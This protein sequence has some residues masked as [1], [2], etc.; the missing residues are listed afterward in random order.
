MFRN[1]RIK[2]TA[3]Y[4]LI[5]MCISIAFS[6]VIYRVLS[7]EVERFAT[8]QRVRIERRIQDRILLPNIP[9]PDLHGQINLMD[10]DLVGETQHRLILMLLF[11]NS[12][13]LLIAGALGYVLAGK[14][15]KPIASMV[16]EQHRFI[17]DASHELRTPITALKTS[18]EVGLRDKQ[19]TITD[20]KKLLSENIEEINSLQVLSEK[21]LQ[22]S[23]YES[24]HTELHM[25]AFDLTTALLQAI[26]AVTPMAKKKHIAI[27]QTLVQQ[28]ILGFQPE[29]RDLFIILL[30]N[31]IKYSK[32]DSTIEIGMTTPDGLVETKIIDHGIGIPPTDLPHIFDRFYRG[33][34]VR[35]KTH[36]NGYGL[37]LSI[38]KKIVAV[39]HGTITV[40]SEIQKGS[41]FQVAFRKA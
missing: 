32:K 28:T 25:T 1:A 38:A 22:L 20:A 13:I 26:H 2:L 23:K 10:P 29:I 34:I 6:G 12:G 21:L 7:N 8:A 39:H 19:L 18:I 30:D 35:T 9:P 16:E 14:T 41:T 15:L 40:K 33:D 11:I 17:S 4:L 36:A 3:W 5:I 27:R 31:A 37:G 24:Q